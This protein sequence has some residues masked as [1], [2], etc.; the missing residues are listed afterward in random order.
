MRQILKLSIKPASMVLSL[1]TIVASV[2]VAY[3]ATGSLFSTVRVSALRGYGATTFADIAN[4]ELWRLIT[5]QLIHVKQ[6]HMLYNAVCLLLVGS[7]VESKLGSLRTLA[8]WLFAGGL[9]TYVSPIGI[10]A[11]WD[12][13]TGASQAVFALAAVA[14]VLIFQRNVNRMRGAVLVA[15]SLVPGLALDFM[16]AGYPKPGHAV[17]LFLGGLLGLIFHVR[18]CPED[19]EPR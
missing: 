17:A 3:D 10:K 9:A 1:A 16:T 15:F 13:G 19:R 5:A 12:A 6:G 11:P 18:T 4:L 2:W 8:I 14:L 7:L